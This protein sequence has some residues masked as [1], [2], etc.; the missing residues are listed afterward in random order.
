MY[1]RSTTLGI[2][3]AMAL[4][5]PAQRAPHYSLVSSGAV[6]LSAA[7]QQARYGI[8]DPDPSIPSLL[9]ISIGASGPGSSLQL[10]VPGGR[11]PVP[12]RY[13]IRSGWSDPATG[14]DAFH[15]G[16]AAGS[17][18]HPLGWFQGESGTVTITRAADGLLSGRFEIRARGYLST[19]PGDENRWVT[20]TGSFDAAGDTTATTIAAARQAM[21][22]A[23][24]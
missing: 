16:F 12:G 8:V 19:D 1:A 6:S 13:P 15:A 10:T 11:V 20:V 5:F 22:Q 4:A 24:R 7:G 18:E 17:P 21:Q 14:T 3:S 9:T 23:L 2:L